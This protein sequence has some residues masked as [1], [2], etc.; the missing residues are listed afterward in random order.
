MEI[1]YQGINSLKLISGID[2]YSC[3][4]IHGMKLT[5]IGR[6]TLKHAAGGCSY[7]NNTSAIGSATVDLIGYI[8]RDMEI[9]TVHLVLLNLIHLYRTECSKTNVKCNLSVSNTLC[10]NFLKQLVG[11]VQTCGRCGGRALLLCIYGLI[12]I[13]IFKLLGDIRRQG[14]ISDNVKH[15]INILIFLG[16]VLEFYGTVATVNNRSNGCTKNVGKVKGG[17][18]LCPLSGA[19]KCFPLAIFKHTKKQKLHIATCFFGL[20]EQTCRNNL[21]GIYNQHILR[22]KVVNNIT[23]YLVLYASVIFTKDH[24]TAS[25]TLVT[26]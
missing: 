12:I 5:V 18:D 21:R 16:I 14:H 7:G 3:F 8:L 20:S 1:G 2:E 24:K 11:K 9:L 19:D 22:I 25:V 23:E 13:L 15:L 4:G 17:T 6:G 26:W 10:L